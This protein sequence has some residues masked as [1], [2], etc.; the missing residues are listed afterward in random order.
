MKLIKEIIMKYYMKIEIEFV[1]ADVQKH[2]FENY[3]II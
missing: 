2:L 3:D 1:A